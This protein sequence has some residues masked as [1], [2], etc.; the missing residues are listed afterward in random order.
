MVSIN[1]HKIGIHKILRKIPLNKIL[2]VASK[3]KL[4][5]AINIADLRQCA[6]QRAHKMVFDYLDAGA[7]DEVSLRRGKDAY[8]QLEMHYKVLTGLKPP[9]NMSTKIFGQNVR[10]PFFASPTAGNRM[11]HWEGEIATANAAEH[12]GSLFG[13]SSLATT[14]ITDI[15][16]IHQG[17]K[18]FQLYVWKDHELLRDVINQAREGG[19][20]ALALTVDFTWYGNRERDIRNFFTIPPNYSLVQ[21]I[22]AFRKPAW[23]YDFLSN[24]PYTYACINKDVPADSLASF[25]KSQLSPEFSWNDA[26]WLLGEWNGPVAIKGVVRP[27][28]AVRAVKYGFS[29]VWISNHGGRQLDTSPATIDVLPYIR[30]AVG[31]DVEI[32]LDGGVQRGTDI[33][34][35]LALGADSVGIG[36]PYLYGLCAGG[37][38]GVIKA[39]EILKVELERAMGL[40]GVGCIDQLKNEGKDLIKKRP[41]SSRD[42][43]DVYAYERGYGGG[44]I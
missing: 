35:A 10:I 7:D 16:R 11:F 20:N 18:V 44:V 25:V 15:G 32:I 21:A 12:H 8:S 13:L 6:K 29:T 17:P 9:I 39:I 42:Y 26:E 3:R 23:T 31:P 4:A 28:D 14:G 27:D 19:F 1:P 24:E 41:G 38:N 33:C 34:K 30:E 22:E 2:D 37:T 5:K 43:P 36:K 40:L